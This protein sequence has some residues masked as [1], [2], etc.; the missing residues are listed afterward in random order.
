MRGESGYQREATVKLKTSFSNGTL[1]FTNTH[2]EYIEFL[3]HGESY[4]FV[5]AKKSIHNLIIGTP[6][7]EVSGKAYLYNKACPKER[8]AEIEYF[9]R[10]W[11]ESSYHKLQGSVYSAPGQVAYRIE[12]RYSKTVNLIN[13]KTGEVEFSWTK[14]PYPE[15]WDYMYGMT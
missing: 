9:K 1:Y 12:G 14:Q 11:S 13:A 6:Y 5:P 4:E 8:Y 2:K 10:G 7:L 3:P 15:N